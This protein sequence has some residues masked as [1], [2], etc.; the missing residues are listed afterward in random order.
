MAARLGAAVASR[1]GA[2]RTL[3]LTAGETAAANLAAMGAATLQ[4]LGEVET[5]MPAS[6]AM[7]V[8]GAPLIVRKSGGFGAAD[9][10]SRLLQRCVPTKPQAN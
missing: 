3:L 5:G 6:R 8:P 2:C 4:L 9:C 1:L 10:L 7:H